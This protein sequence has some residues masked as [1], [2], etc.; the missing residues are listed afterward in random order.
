[1]QMRVGDGAAANQVYRLFIGEAT[2]DGAG[3]VG[4]FKWYGIRARAIGITASWAASSFVTLNHNLG[5]P[6]EQISVEV[7]IAPT[8]AAQHGYQPLTAAS[9]DWV[10][11]SSN[12]DITISN[13]GR[14]QSVISTSNS[15]NIVPS[16]GGAP[17][18]I[19]PANWTLRAVARRNW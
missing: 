10:N 14:L 2:T 16:G 6:G 11:I 1:M 17:V 9:P 4:S 12:R 19:T 15:I 5:Y 3:V 13:F 8:S 7:F 18:A